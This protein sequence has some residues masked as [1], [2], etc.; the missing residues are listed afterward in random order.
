MQSTDLAIEKKLYLRNSNW[1]V[2]DNL[3]ITGLIYGFI[4]PCYNG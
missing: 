2:C 4:G 3:I 1:D